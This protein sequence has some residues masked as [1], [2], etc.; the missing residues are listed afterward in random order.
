MHVEVLGHLTFMDACIEPQPW[1]DIFVGR[2]VP[3]TLLEYFAWHP[4][5]LKKFAR[6]HRTGDV[7]P[8]SLIKDVVENKH[9]FSG[10]DTAQQVTPN[11]SKPL[12]GP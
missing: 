2:Q 5:V 6:H 4:E 9:D 10:L 7:I 12:A 11:C 3:S 1:A 8:D